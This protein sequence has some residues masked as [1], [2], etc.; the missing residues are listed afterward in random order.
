MAVGG[1][2]ILLS[3]AVLVLRVRL[4][5]SLHLPGSGIDSCGAVSDD[6]SQCASGYGRTRGKY[7]CCLFRYALIGGYLSMGLNVTSGVKRE[8]TEREG[9]LGNCFA[10]GLAHGAD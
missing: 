3:C 10:C 5:V 8:E 9:E 2:F 7:S 6:S 4:D 1:K